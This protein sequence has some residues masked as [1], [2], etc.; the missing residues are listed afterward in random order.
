M[1][2]MSF[3]KTF[4]GV[5]GIRCSSSSS[6]CSIMVSSCWNLVNKCSSLSEVLTFQ[7]C[8]LARACSSAAKWLSSK[9]G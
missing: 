2:V 4:G 6:F 1:G 9:L 7:T 8:D 3:D 5:G